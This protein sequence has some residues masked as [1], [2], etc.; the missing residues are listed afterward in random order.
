VGKVTPNAAPLLT[1]QAR[2]THSRRWWGAAGAGNIA[3]IYGSN[4][5]IITG[6]P[7]VLPLPTDVNGTQVLIGGIK[8]PIYFTSD[9]Q[10]K[11]ADS[12]RTGAEQTIPGD[13]RRQRRAVPPDSSR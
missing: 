9:G 6:V 3:A 2:C 8:A 1:P 12:V 13:C 10:V 5:A 11:R 4:L 7:N